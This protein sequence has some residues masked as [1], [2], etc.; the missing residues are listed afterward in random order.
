MSAYYNENDP[1]AAQPDAFP[2][3]HGVLKRMGKLRGSGNAIVP[4]CAAAFVA[5]CMEVAA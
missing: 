1:F 3:A 2:V 4:Q 5:S